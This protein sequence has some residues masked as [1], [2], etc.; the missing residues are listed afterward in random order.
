MTIPCTITAGDSLS[1]TESFAS[2]L[3]ISGWSL[4]YVLL[5]RVGKI[6]FES[7]PVNGEFS[8]TVLS[9]DS[10]SWTPGNYKAVP[11]LTNGSQRV[12]LDA[13]TVVVNPDPLAV[14]SMDTRSQAQKI[15][16]SLRVAY[17]SFAKTGLVQEVSINGRTTKFRSADDILKQINYWQLLVNSEENNKGAGDSIGFGKRIL[18]SL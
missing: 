1:F 12:T 3:P 17:E 13:V 10:Q 5:N 4:K 14:E 8:F 9:A 11:I 7:S 15:L 6:E 18:T 16:E 2:Y